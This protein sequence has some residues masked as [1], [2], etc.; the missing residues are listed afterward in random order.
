MSSVSL[1]RLRGGYLRRNVV[2]PFCGSRKC[3]GRPDRFHIRFPLFFLSINLPSISLVRRVPSKGKRQLPES[4]LVCC[5]HALSRR[6]PLG[7]CE[8]EVD[9]RFHYPASAFAFIRFSRRDLAQVLVQSRHPRAKLGQDGC[10][11]SAQVVVEQSRVSARQS[12]VNL[13]GEPASFRCVEQVDFW[14]ESCS[15]C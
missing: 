2:E 1:G 8:Q 12:L 13:L 11:G 5:P 3:N 10:I 14:L 7:A 15:L 4:V 6:A 9:H